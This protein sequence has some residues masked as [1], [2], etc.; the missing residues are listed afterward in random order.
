MPIFKCSKCG[1][2]DNTATSGYWH[3]FMDVNPGETPPPAL[4]SQCDPTIGTWHDHFPRKT[5]IELGVVEG[6]DGFYY[7]PED[8]YLE[9]LRREKRG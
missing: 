7:D 2:I 3:R 1:V 6:P 4:C 8:E 9:R 5:A